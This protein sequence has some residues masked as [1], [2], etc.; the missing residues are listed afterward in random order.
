[1]LRSTAC[2]DLYNQLLRQ[3]P[4]ASHAARPSSIAVK[5]ALGFGLGQCMFRLPLSSP[6]LENVLGPERGTTLKCVMD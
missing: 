4:I 5:A 2:T 1:M 6:V 3:L